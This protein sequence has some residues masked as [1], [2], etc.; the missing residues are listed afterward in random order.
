MR[1]GLL[2]A[3][4]LC[5]APVAAQP[6]AT[7]HEVSV[8]LDSAALAAPL[9]RLRAAERRLAGASSAAVPVHFER[10][11]A[12]YLL[13][14]EDE[15]L[16]DDGY[17][18]IDTL[19]ARFAV[20]ADT[21]LLARLEGYTGAFTV[22]RAKHSFWPHHKLAHVRAGL[23]QLDVAVTASP[24]DAVLRYLRL[25]SGFYL[26]GLFG[27]GDE[28]RLDFDALARLLPHTPSD[29]PGEMYA[30]VITFVL[31]HGAPSHERAAELRSLLDV[32]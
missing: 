25:M 5:S 8:S 23:R 9:R 15:D 6:P 30:T 1:T 32:H 17:A 16:I 12:L 2:G 18:A 28:V 29:F 10:L 21:W 22:L 7:I 4:L 3:F 31:E 14:V 26:P 27:R 11:G 13:A 19:H 24:D 20:D